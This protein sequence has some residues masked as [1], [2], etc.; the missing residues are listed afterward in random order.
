MSWCDFIAG[1][2]GGSTGLICG[3]P[4]DT[5]KVVQQAGSRASMLQV[6]ASIHRTE[7]VAGYFKGML[8]P[9]LTAGAINSV[10]FGVYGVCMAK[11]KDLSPELASYHLTSVYLAGVAGGT[12]QLAIASPVELVKIRLQT[13][14]GHSRY[15][16]PWHCLTDTLRQ[17]GVRGVLTG[18][19]PHWWRDGHGFGVYVV[20]YEA[21]L[22][23]LGGRDSVTEA[24]QFWAGGAAGVICWL[25]VL[26]AD[27]VKSR[28]QADDL[29]V[30]GRRYSGMLDC[31]RQSYKAEGLSVFFRGAVAMSA[32]AFPVNGVTFYVYESLLQH[33]NAAQQ[34]AT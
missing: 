28:M 1:W 16:G 4:L 20:L 27:V 23:L 13:Q 15:R 7:G 17:H 6:V 14:T 32:R 9:V 33:C 30:T 24:E 11:I 18:L 26:P 12:V 29:S 22:R 25:S 5:V 3:H 8:Y 21:L 10:F 19:V 2:V 31:A 34:R